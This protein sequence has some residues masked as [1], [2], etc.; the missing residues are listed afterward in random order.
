SLA[1]CSLALLVSLLISSFSISILAVYME[2]SLSYIDIFQPKVLAQVFVSGF[3]V[4]IMASLLSAVPLA[5]SNPA[6]LLRGAG[7]DTLLS[8]GGIRKALVIVQ[9]AVST[10]LIIGALA[11]DKQIS[12]ISSMPKG[13]ESANKLI[14]NGEG[15]A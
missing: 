8:N 3:C 1:L 13:F 7:G 11:I 10:G 12:Y 9:F 4:T 14:L 2:R 15:S 5:R 6:T